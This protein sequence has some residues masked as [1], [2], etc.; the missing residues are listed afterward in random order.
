MGGADVV[1]GV[2]VR[3]ARIQILK[4]AFE[5][6]VGEVVGFDVAPG[7]CPGGFSRWR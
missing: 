6:V 3:H 5:F 4:D 7:C 1:A 2:V